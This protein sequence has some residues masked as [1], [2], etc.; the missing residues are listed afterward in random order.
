MT[1]LRTET[2]HHD[3]VLFVRRVSDLNKRKSS[4]I[5]LVEDQHHDVELLELQHA[6]P[7]L[8]DN[9]TLPR[10][11]ILAIKNPYLTFSERGYLL[12][13]AH[14]SDVVRLGP[15]HP[16]VPA[17]FMTEVEPQLPTLK[18]AHQHKAD[19]N[20]ALGRKAVEEAIRS[21][22]E[23]I[24]AVAEDDE[25]STLHDLYRNRAHANLLVGRYDAAMDDALASL[26]D[27]IDGGSRASNV[28]AF[29]RAGKAAYHLRDY[30][31]A[32]H[33]FSQ[34][35]A[36]DE[37]C[38]AMLDAAIMRL[39]EQT[40]GE[41]DFKRITD[42]LRPDSPRLDV[43]DFTARTEIKEIAGRGRGLVATVD[44]SPGELV[45]CEKAFAVVFSNEQE[46]FESVQ[47]DVRTEFLAHAPLA[48]WKR[49]MDVMQRS[50]SLAE[51][52]TSLAGGWQGVGKTITNVDGS[53]V[54][55]SFQIHDIVLRNAFG[56]RDIAAGDASEP[57]GFA[58][59]VG[60]DCSGLWCH[61]SLFNHSCVPNVKRVT[62]G[63]VMLVRATKPIAKGEEITIAYKTFFDAE[64]KRLEQAQLWSFQCNCLICLAE[65]ADSQALKRRRKQLRDE[66]QHFVWMYDLA[67][68]FPTPSN[69]AE[70]EKLAADIKETY[71]SDR[72]HGVPCLAA[73]EITFWLVVAHY[74][75]SNR[76]ECLAMTAALLTLLAYDDVAI[77]SQ[78]VTA[79]PGK[80]SLLTEQAVQAV[81]LAAGTFAP[82]ISAGI[83]AAPATSPPKTAPSVEARG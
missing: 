70:A 50:P 25:F 28:K 49:V 29:F 4:I 20:T 80:G 21:Y 24:L 56:A 42:A 26:L 83:C 43:A 1:D 65:E 81:M 44:I 60:S 32:R 6:D 57:Y 52:V 37:Y 39:T 45:L 69:I 68:N 79:K 31:K 59:D 34:A 10:D 13:I 66:A 36:A 48:L 77:S 46:Y 63:D 7:Y 35:A 51:R 12:H 64:E 16:L 5:A 74:K 18:S 23:G 9:L 8:R 17:A 73:L 67:Y 62:I 75:R 71:A 19:G 15:T 76:T 2:H 72:Y 33:F 22:T 54:I 53:A 11:A 38:Q 3:Q 78:Q 47:Y 55:D 27:D 58:T 61:A 40:T 82:Y 14:P 30:G 41:Y